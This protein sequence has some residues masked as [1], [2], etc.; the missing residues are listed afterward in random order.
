MVLNKA[1]KKELVSK[2]SQ[3]LAAAKSV[4]F[5]DF[6]GLAASDVEKLRARLRAENIR[7]KVVK[8]TLLKRILN[9]LKID[10]AAFNY[11]V[12]LAVSFG[13]EDEVMPAKLL[14]E[15]GRQNENLKIV[16]GILDGK[17]IDENQVK[18]LATLPGK[19]ELLGQIVG[20]VASPLRGL[21]GVLSGNIRSLVYA[22][23]AISKTKN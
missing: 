10:A 13:S 18:A 17:L 16:G 6:Q 4:V 19:Q 7:H 23:Q 15:F 5:S 20:V 22:F 11:T 8:L 21:A 2:L 9:N 12:P 3:D 14:Y 1:Q